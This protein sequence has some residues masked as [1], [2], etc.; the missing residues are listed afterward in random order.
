MFTARLHPDEPSVCRRL[1]RFIRQ[2][3]ACFPSTASRQLS[4]EICRF[5]DWLANEALA[6]AMTCS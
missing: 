5:L 2:A 6:E 1:A 3:R 4:P